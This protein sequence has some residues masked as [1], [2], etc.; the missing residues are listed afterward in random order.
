MV[1]SRRMDKNRA[2]ETGIVDRICCGLTHLSQQLGAAL[3][4]KPKSCRAHIQR[5]QGAQINRRCQCYF[6]LRQKYFLRM[7]SAVSSRTIGPNAKQPLNSGLM[8]MLEW[9]VGG[10]HSAAA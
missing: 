8:L 3:D 7:K 4:P 6:G 10:R 5:N 2:S 1:D 9:M